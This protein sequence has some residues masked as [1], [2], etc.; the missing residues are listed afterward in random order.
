MELMKY[1]MTGGATVLGAMRAIA[2]LKPA[3]PVLG[4]S[5]VCRKFAFGKGNKAG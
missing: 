5:A 3:V 4:R 2:Q 1:D